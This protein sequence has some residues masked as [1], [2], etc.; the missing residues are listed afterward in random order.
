MASLYM[1]HDAIPDGELLLA[2]EPEA[3]SAIILE[4]IYLLPENERRTVNALELFSENAVYNYP[5]FNRGAIRKA[6]MGASFKYN[7]PRR[8]LNVC[9]P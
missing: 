7:P 5:Q 6:L 4:C 3:L 9:V 1:L 2:H 8:E